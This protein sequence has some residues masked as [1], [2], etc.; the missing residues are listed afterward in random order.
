MG[1]AAA[2]CQLKLR[3]VPSGCRLLSSGPQQLQGWMPAGLQ[4]GLMA[5]EGVGLWGRSPLPPPPPLKTRI[6][7]DLGL[8][9]SSWVAGEMSTES[10]VAVQGSLL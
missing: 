2:A 7:G 1:R 8:W 3:Q 9:A 6:R 4:A 10:F 5:Q